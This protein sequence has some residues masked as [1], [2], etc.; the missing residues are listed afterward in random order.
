MKQ[1]DYYIISCAVCTLAG[2]LLIDLTHLVCIGTICLLFGGIP[3]LVILIG[4]G[5]RI[6][7]DIADK[8]ENPN[9]QT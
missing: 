4:L 9:E 7:N 2:A 6:S 8:Q 3:L 1:N 5:F